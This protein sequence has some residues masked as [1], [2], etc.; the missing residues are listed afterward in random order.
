MGG[1]SRQQAGKV[2][3][4]LDKQTLQF[5]VGPK[6]NQRQGPAKGIW[7]VVAPEPVKLPQHNPVIIC[8]ERPVDPVFQQVSDSGLTSIMLTA[9]LL[10]VLFIR[11]F[12]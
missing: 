11:R 3:D 12:N 10:V 8:P 2:K 9:G 5:G 1:A 7:D 4:A 6:G